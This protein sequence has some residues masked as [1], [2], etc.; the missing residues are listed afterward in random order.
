M[1]LLYDFLSLINY[2]KVASKTTNKPVSKKNFEI[3][4]LLHLEGHWQKKQQDLEPD[5]I[6]RGTDPRIRIRTV[7]K[8][9]ESRNTVWNV[10]NCECLSC[11]VMDPHWFN[12]LMRIR[13]H[14]FSQLRCRIP[15]RIQFPIQGFD[16]QKFKKIYSCKT[17][18]F[19]FKSKIAIYLSLGLYK[20]RTS[21]KTSLQ[22]SK[23]NIQHFKTWK[24]LT[25]FL[26][27]CGSFWPSW[28]R[29]GSGNSNEC[30][31]AALLCC[32]G[33]YG[34]MCQGQA[35][36]VLCRAFHV[37][38]DPK[39][40]KAARAAVQVFQKSSKVPYLYLFFDVDHDF[41][42]DHDPTC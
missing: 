20:W 38:K 13:I 6:V 42:G 8:C 26:N 12:H 7:A 4:F 5:P 1:W 41:I 36:S 19:F 10:L 11:R 21:Y 31:S 25:F 35:I 24:F 34:A 14:N 30:G 3:F 40:L 28:I 15:I 22:S 32:A 18:V 27:F 16:E 17:F 2:I 23:E 39:Y 29:T 9:H 37:S 33:W